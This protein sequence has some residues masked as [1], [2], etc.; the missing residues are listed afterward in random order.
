M[1]LRV[2]N[3]SVLLLINCNFLCCQAQE[4]V[5]QFPCFLLSFMFCCWKNK[6]KN[7]LNLSC[8]YFYQKQFLRKV[9]TT[10]CKSCQKQ[11]ILD[12]KWK[13]YFLPSFYVILEAFLPMIYFMDKSHFDQCAVS[14][15]VQKV[16]YFKALQ[17]HGWLI[18][19]KVLPLYLKE[20]FP[21]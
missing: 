10:R 2:V 6:K 11:S 20:R 8:H 5:I 13:W 21:V 19:T 4:K 9:R 1:R 14:A 17:F 16:G 18:F 12:L 3:N 15:F 7:L